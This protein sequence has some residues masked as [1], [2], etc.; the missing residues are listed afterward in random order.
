MAPRQQRMW[1]RRIKVRLQTQPSGAPIY[2]GA[3][4]CMVKTLRKEGVRGLFKVGFGR[5]A[6]A[7]GA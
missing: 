7:P 1:P 3:L 6:N 2:Q 4:D 5:R